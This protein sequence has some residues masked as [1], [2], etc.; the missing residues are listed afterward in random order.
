MFVLQPPRHIST[1]RYLAVRP[2]SSEGPLSTHAGQISG[3]TGTAAAPA[4]GGADLSKYEGQ[5]ITQGGVRYS[6][7]GAVMP[8]DP[9]Q[10]FEVES[11]APSE[12]A[13]Y[14]MPRFSRSG[15]RGAAMGEECQQKPQ[16]SAVSEESRVG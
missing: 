7:G 9:A 8:F 1:L 14:F 15:D 3:D 13:P 2:R 4:G 16:R 10:P 12:S 5:I 11:G 6:P